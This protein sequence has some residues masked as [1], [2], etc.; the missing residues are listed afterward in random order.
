M[1]KD[2]ILALAPALMVLGGLWFGVMLPAKSAG[3]LPGTAASAAAPDMKMLKAEV[4]LATQVA[5]PGGE[6]KAT[7]RIR[8]TGKTTQRIRVM[9]CSWPDDWNTDSKAIFIP[10][11]DCVKNLTYEEELA[12]N[13]VYEQAGSLQVSSEA[14]AGAVTFKCGFQPFRGA[15]RIWTEAMTVTVKK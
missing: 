5:M 4:V 3:S 12:P 8:N 14:A 11:W 6:I 9:S 2:K 15:T 1:R 7:F 13:S 10:A